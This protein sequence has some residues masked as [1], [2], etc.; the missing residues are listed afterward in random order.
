MVTAIHHK[1]SCQ[2]YHLGTVC[3]CPP[4]S[5]DDVREK[6]HQGLEIAEL[7]LGIGQSGIHTANSNPY[8]TNQVSNLFSSVWILIIKCMSVVTEES[9]YL[10]L[11]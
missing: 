4:E 10:I 7:I 6:K 11:S 9:D 2:M 8:N 1:M 5:Q 3:Q